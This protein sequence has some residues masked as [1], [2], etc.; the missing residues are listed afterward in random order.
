MALFLAKPPCARMV[1]QHADVGVG[2]LELSL[3]P[4]ERIAGGMA[5]AFGGTFAATAV[6]FLRAPFPL[7]FKLVPLAFLAVGV[8]VST[9]GALQATAAYT[10]H[11]ERGRGVA[12]RW[13]WGRT[14]R[15]IV[16]ASADIEALEIAHH[17]VHHS[18]TMSSEW[19]SNGADWV[20][21][22][23]RLMLVTKRGDAYPIER[24]AL[25]SQAALRQGLLEAVLRE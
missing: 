22:Q 5:A 11:V 9:F 8:T 6:R 12:Y 4:A 25:R 1:L 15:E 21:M 17:T 10:I 18:G 14:G 20:E 19:A 16:V 2:R 7:P 24:F 13:R 3:A 23:Y